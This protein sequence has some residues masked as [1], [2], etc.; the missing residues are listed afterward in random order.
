MTSSRLVASCAFTLAALTLAPATARAQQ[1]TAADIESARQLYNQGVE[2]RDKGDLPGALEKLRAAHALGNTPITGLELCRT[3][4][5][6]KQPVEARE[7]CL[8]V[9]RIAP[10]AAETPRSQEARAEAGRL[11]EQMKAHIGLLRLR[12]TGVPPGRAPTVVV[13]G[14]L[15]PTAALGEPRAV[16]PGSHD[17][18]AKVGR[19][20]E[21][22]ARIDVR[23]GETK[24]LDLAV[25]ALADE[26]PPPPPGA[27]PQ[28][29][30]AYPP[31][32]PPEKKGSSL[33]TVGFVIAGVAG[34]IG[35][36]AGLV[37]LSGKSELDDKCANKICGVDEHDALDRAKTWG[38]V[39]TGMF[40]VAGAGLVLGLAGTLTTKSSSST[41][42]VHAPEPKRASI[43]P[44]IGPLGVGVHGSF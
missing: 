42:S 16:D 40:V 41:G 3:H 28:G 19:G 31:S 14:V 27:Q 32:R 43:T 22:R 15:V 7:V 18:M 2:L 24:D 35:A 25:Q 9:A 21:S 33:G 34:G 6:L 10:T 44:D 11:A 38:N 12:I 23:E 30:Y 5:A 1:R 29:P 20:P 13:D 8:G 39:S 4:A 36:V 17:I 26:P 37:A